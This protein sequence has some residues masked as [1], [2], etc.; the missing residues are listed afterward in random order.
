M[1][2]SDEEQTKLRQLRLGFYQHAQASA[3]DD[4]LDFITEFAAV[5]SHVKMRKA[6][7]PEKATVAVTVKNSR[8]NR[9]KPVS[10]VSAEFDQSVCFL[11][12]AKRS[13]EPY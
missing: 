4:E 3:P 1:V 12:L 7:D 13:R 8:S 5:L 2:Y 11:F 10:V 6:P 9:R